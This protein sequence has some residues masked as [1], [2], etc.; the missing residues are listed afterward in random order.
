MK[1]TRIFILT[2]FMVSLSV[3]SCKDQLI[4]MNIDPN[5]ANPATTNPNLVLS[6]VLTETARSYVNLGYQDIAGVMQHTQKDGWAGSHNNFDWNRN[7]NWT[8]Y[9]AILRNNQWVYERSVELG[10]EFQ[11]GV[12]LVIKAMMFG[13]MTDLWGDI[14]FSAALKGARREPQDLYPTFDPQEQIYE[15][16]LADLERAN[17]LFSKPAGEY[18]GIVP[19]IDVYYNGNVGRWR[20]LS[21]SLKLRYYMRLS[22]KKPAVAKAGIENIIANPTQ[23]PIITN[24]SHD[25]TMGFAGV[26]NETSWPANAVFDATGSNYRRLKMCHTLVEYMRERS[27]PRLAVW[28]RPVQ[29]PL[30]VD[31]NLPAGTDRI[32][33]GKR[34]LS[35]TTLAARG[36]TID[37]INTNQDFVGIP[38]SILGPQGFNLSPDAQQASTNPHVSWLNPMYQEATGPMLRVRLMP[39]SEVRF[40]L[41]E[42]AIKGWAVGSAQDHYNA[43]IQASFT[44]WGVANQAAAYLAQ[45]NV[46]F[47]GTVKQIIE[48]KWVASWTAATEAWFDYRRTGF[49]ELQAGPVA[50]RTVLPIRFYYPI[51][52][53]N[54][55]LDNV[56]AASARLEITS[57]AEIDGN[58]SAWSR[59]WI[60]QGTG[61]PW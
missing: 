54:L 4:E 5:G 36:L 10:F 56:E 53:Q 44:T 6:T 28:A 30:V 51:I 57:F 25:A 43:A 33:G 26:S 1:K 7:N 39:A 16:I 41:A 55:N 45:P 31:E 19:S 47:D 14:P 23:F 49:P 60:S 34:L 12:T 58:N 42:A 38:P 17:Q 40:I 29:T 21:N 46:A 11:Q 8:G 50:I 3:V 59:P 48:Q 15:A 9:Y 37:D 32:E 22:D 61:R 35:P 18:R 27:D 52:E 2:V 20:Q 13:L 24:P